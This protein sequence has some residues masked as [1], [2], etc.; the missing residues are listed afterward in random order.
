MLRLMYMRRIACVKL[1]ITLLVSVDVSFPHIMTCQ[2][3][4]KYVKRF[5]IPEQN[6]MERCNRFKLDILTVTCLSN[7]SHVVFNNNFRAVV[8][9]KISEPYISN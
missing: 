4:I 2:M 8:N 7:I 6:A 1:E 5:E 9:M 3:F